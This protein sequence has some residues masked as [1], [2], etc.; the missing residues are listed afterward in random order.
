MKNKLTDVHFKGDQKPEPSNLEKL[1]HRTNN[2]LNTTPIDLG[3]R[4]VETSQYFVVKVN[5]TPVSKPLHTRMLAEQHLL[6]LPVE[7]QHTAEI[8]TVNRN[9]QELLLG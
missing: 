7:S 5:G 1:S 6:S 3:L 9:G 8:I 2:Q 4:E